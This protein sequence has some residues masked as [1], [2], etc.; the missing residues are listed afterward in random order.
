MRPEMYATMEIKGS[1]T[2][3]VLAVPRE[4][5][6]DI[7]GEKVVFLA[8]GDNSFAKKVV[9]LGREQGDKIE[10]TSGLQSGQRV[11]TKGG[12]FIKTE[13]LKGTLADK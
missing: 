13:F 9:E 3:S 10:I 2:A 1:A 12:F 5:I 8:L 4:A 6:Q 11:V 7:N